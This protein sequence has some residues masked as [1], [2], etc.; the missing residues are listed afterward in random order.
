MN[1]LLF[2]NDSYED[3]KKQKPTPFV[4]I[5]DLH[6]YNDP[7]PRADSQG[8]NCVERDPREEDEPRSKDQDDEVCCVSGLREKD[9]VQ[10]GVDQNN[11]RQP[12]ID[13]VSPVRALLSFPPECCRRAE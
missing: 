6:C 3:G 5:R 8:D 7:D 1:P 13:Q 4:G 12:S 9:E 11:A 2:K 10:D